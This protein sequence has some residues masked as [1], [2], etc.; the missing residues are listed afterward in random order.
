MIFR[1]KDLWDEFE[2]EIS[3]EDTWNWKKSKT[4]KEMMKLK[5]SK[6]KEWF[7][8]YMWIRGRGLFLIIGKLVDE[9]KFED[10]K[11]GWLRVVIKKKI[12]K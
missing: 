12:K 7:K 6:E 5:E 2:L 1:L 4:A 3:V 11:S 8:W 9:L 10:T